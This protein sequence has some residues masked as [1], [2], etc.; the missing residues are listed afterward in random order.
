MITIIR[1]WN[2]LYFKDQDQIDLIDMILMNE[3]ICI[4]FILLLSFTN[5]LCQKKSFTNLLDFTQ[6]F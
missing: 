1:I 6:F 4:S 2:M 3:R 5:L